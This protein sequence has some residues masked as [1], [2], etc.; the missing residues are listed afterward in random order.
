M[1]CQPELIYSNRFGSQVIFIFPSYLRL[2][3]FLAQGGVKEG[4]TRSIMKGVTQKWRQGARHILDANKMLALHSGGGR[5]NVTSLMNTP[6]TYIQIFW[7]TW[8]N[9]K[10]EKLLYFY[11]NNQICSHTY[12]VIKRSH[13]SHWS[14]HLNTSLL[15]RA[16]YQASFQVITWNRTFWT[17]T[18]NDHL[19]TWQIESSNT[20]NI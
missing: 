2:V 18:L 17:W 11:L 3:P 9:Q 6:C 20:H 12:Q 8:Q 19:N 13:L 15:I 16:E 5:I 10:V 14:E 7:S 1:K 4:L